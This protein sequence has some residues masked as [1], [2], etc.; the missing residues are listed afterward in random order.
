VGDQ[1]GAVVTGTEIRLT[2]FSHGAGCA[3]KLGPSELDEVLAM[4]GPSLKPAQVIVSEETGDDAAVYALADGRAL[5]VTVD[6]FTPV[7]DD[8][9]DWGRIAAA[10]ALSDVYAMGGTP[11]LA[12][13]VA[14][15]PVDELPLAMLGDVLLGGRAIADEAS[16]A[17]VGGHTI[18]TAHEPIYGMVAVGLVDPAHL[19]RNDAAQP[20]MDLVLT[21][22]LGIGI[23][24][25][26]I[27]RGRAT[28][29]QA[30]AAVETMTT[31]NAA[32]ARAAVAT[33][34]T[35]GTDVTGFGLLGHLAKMLGASGASATI[36]AEAVPLLDGVGDLAIGDVIPSGTKRNHAWV[37]PRTDWGVLPAPEQMILADAQTSGGLLLATSDPDRLLD[38]LGAG[39]VAA[40]RIGRIVP[41]EPGTIAVE[42]R[43]RPT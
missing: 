13:N 6:V 20:G 26:A 41:G 2:S 1:H 4:L 14:G 18:T 24:T 36:D 17:V 42:G 23:L 33:A 9:F 27:K 40:S 22:P 15:W 39:Q 32:A 34:V 38:A 28:A 37:S 25:T 12:L 8:P 5:V 29:A 35:A 19:I 3:C 30:A 11:I 7:V 10:N 21:K 16:I 31:L 43:L